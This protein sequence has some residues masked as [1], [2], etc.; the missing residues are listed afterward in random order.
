MMPAPKNVLQGAHRAPR[1]RCSAADEWVIPQVAVAWISGS[2]T[3]MC[4]AQSG[5]VGGSPNRSQQKSD[6]RWACLRP[7]WGGCRRSMGHAP[8]FF[9]SGT[10]RSTARLVTT[11]RDLRRR[12][13]LLQK[14]SVKRWLAWIKPTSTSTSS[15]AGGSPGSMS[16][17]STPSS[18]MSR[19]RAS[20]SSSAPPGVGNR[21]PINFG[22]CGCFSLRS[23][24]TQNP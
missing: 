1:V 2:E 9:I 23:G 18:S 19:M 5:F 4:D 14:S 24:F 13:Y 22:K 8:R 17:T 21:L 7:S 12:G 20:T 6:G 16:W 11:I 15:V 3:V 10:D